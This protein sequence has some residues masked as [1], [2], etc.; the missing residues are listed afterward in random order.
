MK[1]SF[2][3]RLCCKDGIAIY[4]PPEECN[5]PPCPNCQE[6]MRYFRSRIR[7]VIPE[8]ATDALSFRIWDLRCK[9][10]H[11][12]HRLEPEGI[13]PY[14]RH[15]AATVEAVVNGE[16]PAE[17]ELSAIYRIAIWWKVVGD[18][19]KSIIAMLAAQAK[20]SMKSDLTFK[21]IISTVTNA[22]YWTFPS[23]LSR[24]SPF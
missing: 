24:T 6:R 12:I 21:S 4:I 16:E 20:M 14:K 9:T 7:W 18:Y 3:C 2:G 13:V 23:G 11:K 10:C 19:F 5:F 22:G 8:G 15:C 17:L 1:F